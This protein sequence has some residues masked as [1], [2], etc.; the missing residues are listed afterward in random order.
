MLCPSLYQ[1]R[2]LIGESTSYQG[3]EDPIYS[4]LLNPEHLSSSTASPL[5]SQHLTPLHR[6][7]GKFHSQLES[8]DDINTS[9]PFKLTVQFGSAYFMNS[10][11]TFDQKGVTVITVAEMETAL[12]ASAKNR[13]TSERASFTFQPPLREPSTPSASSISSILL[14]NEPINS[15]TNFNNHLGVH[16]R[17]FLERA[18]CDDRGT[19]SQNHPHCNARFCHLSLPTI[20]LMFYC[21]T[22]P[23]TS[24]C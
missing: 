14:T 17:P 16:E 20:F 11:A 9:E 3:A 12:H 5:P 8:V 21:N 10:D 6:I 22:T 13:T 24:P 2:S 7:I 4:S 15:T 1:T 18:D 19:V 23:P